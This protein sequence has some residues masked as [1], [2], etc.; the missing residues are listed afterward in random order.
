MKRAGRERW[1]STK[2]TI[3]VSAGGDARPLVTRLAVLGAVE[4]ELAPGAAE[5]LAPDRAAAGAC[6]LESPAPFLSAGEEEGASL[7]E[8][9]DATREVAADDGSVGDAEEE[10]EGPA[11]PPVPFTPEPCPFRPAS[12]GAAGK[13]VRAAADAGE[14]NPVGPTPKPAMWSARDEAGD[15]EGSGTGAAAGALVLRRPDIGE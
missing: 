5:G 1:E 10:E 2:K 15:G 9:A 7:G 12:A 4:H 14:S 11:P 3:A 8:P 6:A 13:S